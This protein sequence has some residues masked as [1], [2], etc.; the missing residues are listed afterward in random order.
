MEKF[1]PRPKTKPGGTRPF[2]YLVDP[3]QYIE[4]EPDT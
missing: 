1:A 3:L 2:K 4:M